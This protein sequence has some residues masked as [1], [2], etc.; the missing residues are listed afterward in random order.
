MNKQTNPSAYQVH[1]TSTKLNAG[2]LQK[3]YTILP[4]SCL[5]AGPIQAPEMA[6]IC[7][8]LD[9]L[10]IEN[11]EHKLFIP[12]SKLEQLLTPERIVALLQQHDIKF[13][14]QTETT[15]AVLKNGLRLFATLA[16][17]RG[18]NLITRFLEADY[19]SG[20]HFD[21]KLPLSESALLTIVRDPERC[22][23]FSRKQWRFLAPVLREDQSHR[24][25]DDRTIMPFLSSTPIGKGGFSN[26]FKVRVDA[27]HH[28]IPSAQAEVSSFLVNLKVS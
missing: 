20:G 3:S 28:R 10:E 16:S 26:V 19:F 15:N 4:F 12:L 9:A 27:S 14:L 25:L 5:N 2:D 24:E 8:E 21:S 11:F 22:L 13:Y 6:D 17:I 7:A 1:S 18:I 23:Q